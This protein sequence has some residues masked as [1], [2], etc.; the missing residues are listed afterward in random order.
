MAGIEE[1]RFCAT[2]RA[3]IE[4][5]DAAL[6]RADRPSWDAWVATLREDV[7][8]A[9]AT[10]DPRAF[11]REKMYFLALHAADARFGDDGSFAHS[12]G[13]A[14]ANAALVADKAEFE[15]DPLRFLR[16]GASAFYR[17]FLNYGATSL[18]LVP[19]RAIVRFVL[20]ELFTIKR[21]EGPNRTPNL[22]LGFLE[23]AVEVLGGEAQ[24]ARYTG[25]ALR[26]DTR[27]GRPLYNQHY[28][29]DLDVDEE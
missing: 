14:R 21:D 24:G 16:L 13:V 25:H 1:T 19:K 9:A 6:A 3:F 12:L 11:F 4:L 27:F 22:L 17:D 26:A 20:S 7:G 29:F 23:R 10:E 8:A 18:E 15:G 5:R 28:E 2:G